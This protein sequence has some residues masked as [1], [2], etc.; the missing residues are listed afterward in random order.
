MLDALLKKPEEYR[1]KVAIAI[2]AMVGILI[3]AV[4]LIATQQNIKQAIRPIKSNTKTASQQFRESLP[5]LNQQETIT[6]ELMKKSKN[7]EIK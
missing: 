4:W 3:F 7:L 5:S 2:T 6:T 1:K